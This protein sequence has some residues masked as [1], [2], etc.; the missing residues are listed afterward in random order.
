MSAYSSSSAF[1]ATV[2][3]I[4]S[5]LRNVGRR[6]NYALSNVFYDVS[7]FKKRDDQQKV[8]KLQLLYMFQD[9]IE[10]DGNIGEFAT[11]PLT[12]EQVETFHQ[13]YTNRHRHW[14][15]R[16]LSKS[17]GAYKSPSSFRS[18]WSSLVKRGKSRDD[19]QEERSNTSSAI[20]STRGDAA[21]LVAATSRLGI[22]NGNSSDRRLS[23]S[24]RGYS[25]TRQYRTTDRHG[26][27]DHHETIH[28][29]ETTDGHETTHHYRLY[30]S[31]MRR[32][33]SRRR[34]RR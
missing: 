19:D 27:T 9:Y 6:T 30:R 22:G 33:K 11:S 2:D 10:N 17:E 21:C 12:W 18:A 25:A 7:E 15:G 20:A 31:Q 34:T 16:V 3:S 14:T 4:D 32:H 5:I 29:Q 28:H 26:T 1:V 23:V 13:E 8:M 24:S